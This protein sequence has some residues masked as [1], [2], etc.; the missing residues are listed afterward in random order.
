[1][2]MRVDVLKAF[3]GNFTT[4][5]DIQEKA[6]PIL[7]KDE[8]AVLRA[9]TASGKTEATIAPL[10][11]KYFQELKSASGVKIIITSPTKAL[12]NDLEKRLEIPLSRLGITVGVKHGDRNSL[13]RRIAPS[14]LITTPES[15][16]V[17]VGERREAIIGCQVVVIDEI[18]QLFNTQRGL[19]IAISI[20]RH[21]LA[22]L[23]PIRVVGI[24]ATSSNALSLWRFFRPQNSVIEVNSDKGRNLETYIRYLNSNEQL[25]ELLSRQPNSK[26]LI[27]CNSKNEVSELATKAEK[28]FRGQR[29]VF[30]HNADLSKS[31]RE[32]VEQ[33]FS[34]FPAA[35]CV[36][37][38]TL[39]IGIDI[40]DID[41]VVQYGIPRS[42]QSLGQRL[43]RGNRRTGQIVGLLC[44]PTHSRT[45]IFDRLAFVPLLSLLGVNPSESDGASLIYGAAIQQ[46]CSEVEARA[47][48]L[49]INTI[50]KIFS[51]W[52]HLTEDWLYETLD[53]LT[54]AGYLVKHGIH[55][56]WGP[57]PKTHEARDLLSLWVN[58]GDEGSSIQVYSGPNH[59]GSM[60]GR[61]FHQLTTG[62]VFSLGS[63]NFQVKSAPSRNRVS[64]VQTGGSATFKIKT[65][66]FDSLEL[67]DLI[68]RT[69]NDL[70]EIDFEPLIHG[71]E[72]RKWIS[73]FQVE[74]KKLVELGTVI[75][76]PHNGQWAHITFAGR[77]M[78]SG[79]ASIFGCTSYSSIAVFGPKEIRWNDLPEKLV[80]VTDKIQ[81]F[82]DGTGSK[83]QRLLNPEYRN[84]EDVSLLLANSCAHKILARLRKSKA[85]DLE[86][87]KNS[88][89]RDWLNEGFN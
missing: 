11:S 29:R 47:S 6:I 62:A 20:N 38:S 12:V 61:N 76:I 64:V 79:I 63:R 82:R 48:Y 1:M 53:E 36:A 57:G 72:A 51:P 83:W 66:A 52:P 70:L 87:E 50:K 3:F 39:E 54:K 32:R 5:S 84:D 4:L 30:G 7:L 19:Q 35:I 71:N 44:V 41:L 86:L 77:S 85:K 68:D 15:Y 45:P 80:E 69:R 55:N 37:T 14:I 43:G 10:V 24:S 46:L 26:V 59:V 60:S 75:R 81:L 67:P 56:K 13:A 25:M 49:G 88:Q 40:G 8:D 73:G 28:Y 22:N 2:E 65:G 18:H 58:F 34:E 31:E 42:W 78:N 74:A 27:F 16:D 89:I 33:Q 21:Q 17:M 23:A 9:P